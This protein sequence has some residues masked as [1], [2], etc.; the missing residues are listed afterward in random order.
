MNNGFVDTVFRKDAVIL[1]HIPHLEDVFRVAK[2]KLWYY[3]LLGDSLEFWNELWIQKDTMQIDCD[4]SIPL[5]D[6]SKDTLQSILN[7]FPN[8]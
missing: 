5:L 1:W 3:E 2:N 7:L 4:A 8:D 6:Q